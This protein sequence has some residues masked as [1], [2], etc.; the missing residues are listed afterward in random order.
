[1]ARYV[2]ESRAMK[3]GILQLV[4]IILKYFVRG[5]LLFALAGFL[6][7]SLGA[8][9]ILGQ[10]D[11]PKAAF[12]ALSALVMGYP[13]ALGMATPLAMIRGGGMA[14]VK[15]I[16]F[17]S[18]EA[19]H[20]FKDAKKVVFDKTGTITEGKPRVVELKPLNNFDVMELLWVA[21]SAERA[22][23]HPLGKAIVE[24]AFKEGV[25]LSEIVDFQN[26]PG[27]G[28]KGTVSGK[29]VYVGNLR[30]L[31]ENGI[32]A[33]SALR[34]AEEMEEN[35]ETVVGVAYEGK[36]I[37]LIGIADQTKEDAPETI[38]KLKKLGIEP[39]IL[40]GDNL[41]TAKAVARKVG[42]EQVI[43]QVLPNEKADVIRRL[44]EDGH[45]VIM[46]GDGINDSPA[47]MQADIGI[48]IGA[49][50][51]IAIESA[52]VIIVGDRLSAVLDAYHIGRKSYSKTKQNLALAFSFNGIGVPLATTGLVHPVWAMVAMGFSV[53][54]V[55]L[56]SFG[57]Q[58]VP[59]QRK[60]E[61]KVEKLMLEI[62]S[63][64][65]ENCVASL[66]DAVSRVKGVI[67]VDGDHKKKRIYVT[68]QG[69]LKL[70]EQIKREI[71][72]K[73][74]IVSQSQHQ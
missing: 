60:R 15:G 20:I 31:V 61:P 42:V 62:P 59:R 63:I 28:V 67:S 53:A 1:V 49:G 46:V 10:P 30:F 5:V 16:L 33:T 51:D 25:K 73:G 4:D 50:T 27:R 19:F 17:R 29:P 2:E 48:A 55:L 9:L 41:R 54:T 65:C 7:W 47:L 68:Y 45:R 66:I 6:V 56:N 57:G 32:E 52:D 3:P 21:G 26:V 69:S 71:I 40:T 23:E 12:A 8:W 44:Q 35:G 37:G 34:N 72:K 11:V 22:S 38:A 58:L 43:A 39:I 74:H 64:H 18:A 14:A 24:H 13:C 70:E 36:L